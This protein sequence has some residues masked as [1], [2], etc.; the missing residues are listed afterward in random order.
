MD[1]LSPEEDLCETLSTP[2]EKIYYVLCV[3]DRGR[4]SISGTSVHT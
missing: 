4:G 1:V 3:V 2:Q